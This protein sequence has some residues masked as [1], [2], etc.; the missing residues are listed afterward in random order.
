[1]KNYEEIIRETQEMTRR[2]E[3][4]WDIISAVL[5]LLCA[6]LVVIG[7]RLIWEEHRDRKERMMIQRVMEPVED[8]HG[9]WYKMGGC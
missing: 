2:M 9:C 6:A 8:E 3:L 4:K 7:I 5:I 1:M